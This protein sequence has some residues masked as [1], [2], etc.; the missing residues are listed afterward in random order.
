M[1]Q[2]LVFVHLAG[3][4]AFLLA[5]GASMYL[6]FRVRRERNRA[7]IAALLELSGRSSQASYGGLLLLGVGG[8]G[9]AY[10]A[11][12]LTAGWIVASYVVIVVVLVAMW[13]IGSYYYYGLRGA[14]GIASSGGGGRGRGNRPAEPAP[15]MDDAELFRQ[16]DTRRPEALAAIGSA[17]LV[18]LVWLMVLKPF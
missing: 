16:L 10:N 6:A 8:L 5:H 18:I 11:S 7:V 2:W 14:L 12:Q 9:A 15:P 17:G 4:V 13:A 1:Y 3:L